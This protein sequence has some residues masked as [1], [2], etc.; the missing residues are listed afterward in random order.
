MRSNSNGLS[1]KNNIF[2]DIN[3]DYSIIEVLDNPSVVIQNTNI[4]NNIISNIQSPNYINAI[5]LGHLVNTKVDKNIIFNLHNS[6]YESSAAINMYGNQN[7]VVSNNTIYNTVVGIK[8]GCNG[9]KL[10]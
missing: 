9:L 2:T 1:I 4:E 5:V 6:N 8:Y 10:K 7:S 3:A